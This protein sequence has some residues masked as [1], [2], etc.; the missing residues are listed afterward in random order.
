M[1]NKCAAFGCTSGYKRKDQ[2]PDDAIGGQKIT[3]HSFPL[4]DKQL[5]EKWVRA[6]PR[7]DFVP[8]KNSKLCSLHF[9]AA[10]FVD[11]HKDTNKQ[12]NKAR[13]DKKLRKRY[14]K[15]DAVPS[16]FTNVPEY[17]SSAGSSRRTTVKATSAQRRQHEAATM[18]QLEETF[19]K[20]DDVA[21]ASIT[22]IA[23]R[24]Q[25]E[26]ATTL[27]GFTIS[28]VNQTLLIYL[29]EI[30][31]DV[32]HIRA[33]ILVKSD[34]SLVLSMD[35]KTIPSSQF[36][37]I[38][39]GR[40]QLL[41]Q[42]TNLMARV[43]SWCDEPRSRSQE[44]MI[45]MAVECL[46]V[47]LQQPDDDSDDDTNDVRKISFIVEQLDLLTKHK[48]G[49]HYSPQLTILSYII[50]SASSAAY[51]TLRDE[52]VLCLPSISTLRKVTRR[53]NE[54][55]GLDSSAYLTLRVSKLNEHER[56]V[57]LMIDE[58]YVAKRVEYSAGEV[59]GL[60]ADGSVASTLLCFMVKSLVGKYKDLVTIY[61]MAKLTAAKQLE[62]FNEVM[63]LLRKVSLNV[64]VISVDNA[65]TNRKFLVDC[66]CDGELKTHITD[67]VTGQP[68]FLIF[69]PVHDLK[70]VYNNF[71]SRKLFECPAMTF[72]LPAGCTAN[73]QHVTDLYNLE[74]V[75]S[76]KKAHRLTP[77]ALQPKSIE[78]T[79]VKLATSVFS[80][81][82]RDALH[83]YAINENK[84]DWNGTADFISLVVKLWNVMNVKSRAKGKH[85]RDI[86]KDPI[87]SSL[88]WK[89]DFLRECADFLERWEKSKRP[90]L[91]RETFLAL[92]HTCLALAEC[93][94][95]LLDRKAFNYVLLG[96]L[97]S[98]AIE[99]RFGWLRQMSGANYYISTRQVLESD[100]KIRAVSLLK[101]SGISLTEIDSAI[102][103]AD[104][105]SS[106]DDNL[107]D[108]LTDALTFH[109]FPS[110]NDANIIFY[111]SGYMARSVI[112]T[113]KCDHCKESLI[114]S[115]AME[116]L[117]TVDEFEYSV[118]T[119][120]D[121]VNRGGLHK[122][123]DFTFLLALH[124]WR[125]F[126]EIKSSP[127]LLQKF[128][129]ATAHRALFC[130][131]MDRACCIQTFGHMPIDS[132]VCVAGHDLNRLLV[133]RFF[134]CVAKNLVKD[135]TA[136]ANATSQQP[137][138]KK[139]KIAK[140]QSG[141]EQQ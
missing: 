66:L 46:K 82:T 15:D 50:Q 88:D 54:D 86:T 130:K 11:V 114:T 113:T 134:N 71:Q 99:R 37:D 26:T 20:E 93:S 135:I 121:A 31:N 90:G 139:R 85:K 106:A 19:R 29:L 32:P 102:Q 131:V 38:V 10:D 98:D 128:L 21:D 140:L 13:A 136:K 49:R 52:D 108:S 95:H 24:L 22:D 81:S 84:S 23:E 16:I 2:Q 43:K 8:S 129:T 76:L 97:Q 119:F 87:R 141:R 6:N 12:R 48:F 30:N 94:A 79:S 69:D 68:V 123:T 126:E 60:V 101:F 25:D 111:V 61:P 104:C 100:R 127:D 107:A 70:N 67:P 73:F 138:K 59:K 27:Q 80:E 17:L 4:H 39:P 91:T 56:N 89:L 1:V 34:H 64:V 137:A 118:S 116:P 75:M 5:C 14:L 133:E 9:Q 125:V 53:V 122:P 40:I 51:T 28:V 47:C 74:S 7:K 92:R 77:A 58:I 105:H 55:H 3:F 117:D 57:V 45:S 65:S 115:D 18:Q 36:K 83:F 124:C 62:C 41:S 78:K 96:H 110:A 44:L 132:N 112:R 109:S 72:N 35:G 33:S 120:L 103:S 63:T 42:L